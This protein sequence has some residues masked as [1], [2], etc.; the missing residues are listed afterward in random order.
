[1][2]S[3]T[4]KIWTNGTRRTLGYVESFLAVGEDYLNFVRSLLVI[5]ESRAHESVTG[6]PGEERVNAFRVVN[7]A[8][9]PSLP[10]TTSSE[11]SFHYR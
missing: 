1:M 4:N 5:V 8:F 9:S 3:S 11:K 10:P 2:T 6:T 7:M